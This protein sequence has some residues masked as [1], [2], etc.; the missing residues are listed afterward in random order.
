MMP[1]ILTSRCQ[2]QALKVLNHALIEFYEKLSSWECSVV[3]GKEFSVAQVQS[4]QV[5]GSRN[6]RLYKSVVIL[7]SRNIRLYKSVVILGSRNIRL[8]KSVVILGA[9]GPMRIKSIVIGIL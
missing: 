1:R 7:G 9:Q 5:L 6:I 8:Y 3:I 4:V 2:M